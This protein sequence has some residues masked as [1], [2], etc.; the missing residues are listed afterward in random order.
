MVPAEYDG[1][2]CCFP[3][4][5]NPRSVAAQKDGRWGLVSPNGKNTA[6]TEFK[7]ESL[8]SLGRTY[9]KCYLFKEAGDDMFGVMDEKGEELVP[10][11]IDEYSIPKD[12]DLLIYRCGDLYGIYKHEDDLF[13]GPEFEK[14]EFVDMDSPVL[15]VQNGVEGGI[16]FMGGFFSKEEMERIDREDYEEYQEENSYNWICPTERQ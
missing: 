4:D 11:V 3:H 6:L 8:E 5:Y 13:V 1:F 12:T 10:A 2:A 9:F 14:I 7:Y 15:A 16:G